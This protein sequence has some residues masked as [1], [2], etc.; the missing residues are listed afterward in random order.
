MLGG[1]IYSKSLVLSVMIVIQRPYQLFLTL[2]DNNLFQIV[3]FQ[4]LTLC[5]SHVIG[6]FFQQQRSFAVAVLCPR[7]T[8]KNS[9][10]VVLGSNLLLR[11]DGC[12]KPPICPV[13]IEI[14]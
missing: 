6:I 7:I 9:V 2:A 13:V 12:E 11:N 5:V 8:S 1:E 10:A 4:M 3:F 14:N